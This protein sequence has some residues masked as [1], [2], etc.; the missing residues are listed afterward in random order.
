[1]QVLLGLQSNALKFTD[2]GK[3]ETIIKKVKNENDEEFLRVSV[4]DTGIGIAQ[5]D[6]NKLFKLFGFVQDQKQVNVS[7]IGLGLVISKQIVEQFNGEI[8]F[9]SIKNVGSQFN[10]TF[11]LERLDVLDNI[12]APENPYMN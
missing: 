12:K 8:T 7:G 2:K 1:M 5:E 9:T 6:Q 3:V 11:K 10:F 4:V